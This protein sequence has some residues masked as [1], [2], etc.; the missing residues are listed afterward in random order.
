MPKKI[1]NIDEYEIYKKRVKWFDALALFL[2]WILFLVGLVIILYY[3]GPSE[4]LYTI[5]NLLSISIIFISFSSFLVNWDYYTA[6]WK[7]WREGKEIIIKEDKG[8]SISA[9]REIWI[10]KDK[11]IKD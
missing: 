6:L 7:G 11:K 5:I 4:E 9:D 1:R 3:K 8:W 2:I 10:K